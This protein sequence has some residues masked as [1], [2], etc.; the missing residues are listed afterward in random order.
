MHTSF[1][2]M[3]ALVAVA[4]TLGACSASDSTRAPA[5][6]ASLI[7]SQDIAMQQGAV[8]SEVVQ[9]ILGAEAY[10][11][12][13]SLVAPSLLIKVDGTLD[14]QNRKVSACTGS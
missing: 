14:L 4:A 1:L 9:N 6:T 3:S 10:T 13:S 11:G 7:I 2:R 8:T 12:T 5:V